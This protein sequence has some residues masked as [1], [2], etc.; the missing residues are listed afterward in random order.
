MD[1]DEIVRRS[2]GPAP[3]SGTVEESYS[4]ESA[5]KT[6]GKKKPGIQRLEI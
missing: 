1:R 4:K 3:S 5:G 6:R 2:D